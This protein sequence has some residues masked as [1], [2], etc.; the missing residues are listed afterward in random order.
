MVSGW[1]VYT[2]IPVGILLVVIAFSSPRGVV[3]VAGV[4]GATGA[5]G[6]GVSEVVLETRRLAR[7]FGGLMAVNEVDLTIRDG[8][9]RAL[10]GPNGAGKTTHQPPVGTVST[11]G[12]EIGGR[13][14]TSRRGPRRAA[15]A[16]ASHGRC[17]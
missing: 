10:I 7:Q 5:G 6:D 4:A 1:I 8:E 9:L 14:E 17:R 12:G 2:Q 3:G 15:L 13:G 16:P 11:S